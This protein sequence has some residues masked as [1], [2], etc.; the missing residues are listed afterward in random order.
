MFKVGYSGEMEARS[1]KD[2]FAQTMEQMITEDKDVV[3]LDADLMN[4]FGTIQLPERFPDQ[5]IDCGI[6]EANMVGVAAGMSVEGKKPYCHTFGVFASRRCFDQVFMSVGYAD[7]SVRIIGSDPGICAMYNGGTHMPFEDVTL[8]RSIPKAAI[9][10]PCDTVQLEAVLRG[11][12]NRKGVT[13]IRSQR[14]NAVKVYD[15]FEYTE[16]KANILRDGSDVV[17]FAVGIMVSEALKAGELLKKRGID[18]C[19]VD[20][21]S[22]KPLDEETVRLCARKC[23]AV[24]TAENSNIRGGVFGA[25][26]E[27]LAVCCPVPSEP[28]GIQDEFGEVGTYE[29]LKKRFGLTAERI[30]EKAEAVIARKHREFGVGGLE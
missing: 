26:A 18:A 8:Y 21:V 27:C 16:G 12:K 30:A 1:F 29:Y 14:K 17:I 28:V 20:L 3:Y 11:T 19:V 10:D 6:Q 9:F 25:I 24:V 23:G 22:V 15:K 13:Y 2:V 7:A 5:A 4:S